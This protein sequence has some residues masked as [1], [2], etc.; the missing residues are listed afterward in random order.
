MTNNLP[1][2]LVALADH[3]AIV[4]I[5]GRA[6]FTTSVPFKRL[7][8]ELRQHGFESFVLDLSEC[9]TMDSTFLGVLAGTALKLSEHSSPRQN[10]GQKGELPSSANLRLLNPNERVWDVAQFL[11]EDLKKL[12]AQAKDAPANQEQPVEACIS[13]RKA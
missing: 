3:V 7:V 6:N 1:S 11:A 10:G 9:V 13:D 5:N 8:T 4:K 12:T 2:L